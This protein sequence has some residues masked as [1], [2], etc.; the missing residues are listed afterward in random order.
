MRRSSVRT[1]TGSVAA[2]GAFTK[3]FLGRV[4]GRPGIITAVAT[5]AAEVRIRIRKG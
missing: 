4:F 1:F 5:A 3:T 2:T